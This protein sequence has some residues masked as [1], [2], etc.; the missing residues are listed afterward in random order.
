M[1]FFSYVVARDYGFAPNPFNGACTLATCKPDIRKSAHIGDWVIGCGSAS[2]GYRGKLIYAM[3]TD[4]IL[5]YSEYFDDP[6]FECKKP[7]LYGSLKQT[8]G[9]NI[10]SKNP[11][12]EWVQLDS[13]HSY[14]DGAQNY[15]NIRRDTKSEKCLISHHY[16]YFG[17]SAITLPQDLEEC[18]Y[19]SR[20]FKY[21]EEKSGVKLTEY[22]EKEYSPGFIDQ[23]IQFNKFSRY[24][25]TT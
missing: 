16:F 17:R 22:L 12:G 3:R 7:V 25:G 14:K 11:Q 13:H 18:I 2:L 23:P 10:Y 21:I 15:H 4:E 9:D 1:N 5:T 8:Y 6:R 20:G 24:N 19:R